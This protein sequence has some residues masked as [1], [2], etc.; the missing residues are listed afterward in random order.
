MPV[1]LLTAVAAGIAT[2]PAATAVA[3]GPPVVL[4][5]GTVTRQDV[6]TQPGCERDTVVEPDVAVSPTDPDVAV[7][8]AHD[9]R[10]P[11]GGAVSISV[12]YTDDG[13]AT[14]HHRPVPGVTTAN[15]GAFD[16]A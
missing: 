7:A 10:F 9:C 12:A 2:A 5:S 4:R 6:P 11:D 13:G 15:G 1:L 16:R 14:W 3:P 8:A